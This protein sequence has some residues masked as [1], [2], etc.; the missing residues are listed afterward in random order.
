MR[1]CRFTRC[2]ED[3]VKLTVVQ[4]S[5]HRIMDDILYNHDSNNVHGSNH[6]NKYEDCYA[7][8]DTDHVMTHR[9][10]NLIKHYY[11]EK[12]KRN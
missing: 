11:L 6:T 1:R 4:V 5:R 7:N 2:V 3:T 10:R 12:K 9:L 8:D